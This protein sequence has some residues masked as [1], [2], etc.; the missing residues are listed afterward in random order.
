MFH[1]SLSNGNAAADSAAGFKSCADK[2]EPIE[3]LSNRRDSKT[4]TNLIRASHA[5]GGPTRMRHFLIHPA[6]G[7][8]R[9][10]ASIGNDASP[11]PALCPN[12][13]GNSGSHRVVFAT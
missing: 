3:L 11:R 8:V 2:E 4:S 1:G 12:H 6:S 5:C 10:V 13:D 9:T 7:S